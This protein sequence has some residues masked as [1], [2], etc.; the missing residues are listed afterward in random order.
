[1]TRLLLAASTSALLLAACGDNR[2]DQDPVNAVQDAASAPVGQMSAATLGANSP[3]AYVTNA[4]MGDMYEIQAA[5]LALE[6]SQNADVRELAEMIRTD[7][8]QASE[9]MR[10]IAGEA[11][12]GVQM[13]TELDERR[14]GMIDN[15]RSASADA[16]DQVYIDQQVAAHQEAVTLHEGFADNTDAPQLA[17][18]AGMVLPKI[19][20]HLERARALDSSMDGAAR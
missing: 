9:Q 14:Q 18:H 11:A 19:R 10:Q 4:A 20:A 2:A 17:Q 13:P 5:E 7:H 3:E 16:F 1:M 15:L 12:A 6:R 8:T